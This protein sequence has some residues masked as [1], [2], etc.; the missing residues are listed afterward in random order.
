[1]DIGSDGGGGG[2]RGP[3]G[4][5]LGGIW[6]VNRGAIAGFEARF[7]WV[8]LR[9][10]CATHSDFCTWSNGKRVLENYYI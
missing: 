4:G 2:H 7:Y 10:R 1:M 5:Y 6:G 3:V 8:L 9:S